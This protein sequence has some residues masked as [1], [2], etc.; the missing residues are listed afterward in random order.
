MRA[1]LVTLTFLIGSVTAQ[2]PPSPSTTVQALCSA[3][4]EQ[5]ARAEALLQEAPR[6]YLL[7]VV[8]ELRLQALCWR[9]A[10]RLPTP[11]AKEPV[12]AVEST[13]QLL[14]QL[15]LH[16]LEVSADLARTWL[17]GEEGEQLRILTPAQRDELLA[18]VK[19]DDGSSI[20][21]APRVTCFDRQS[22]SITITEEVAYI[23]DYEFEV[24]EGTARAEP[25]IS[26]VVD[27]TV[28]EL[29]P[30]ISENR[31]LITTTLDLTLSDLSRPIQSLTTRMPGIP[32]PLELQLPEVT[33]R[34]TETTVTLPDGSPVLLPG[35]APAGEEGPR[36]LILVQAQVV[37]LEDLE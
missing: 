29:T 16:L 26:T 33:V 37:S 6:E 31:R 25:I 36:S 27:G 10:G 22:A 9:G 30:V 3:D 19:G 24:E 2:E 34:Q 17:P 18:A 35:S 28:I 12:P 14:V 23:S 7:A 13:E 32:E 21:T 4:Q 5:R 11:N 15:E 1:T 8:R 20:V